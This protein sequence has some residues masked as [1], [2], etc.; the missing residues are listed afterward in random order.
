MTK[1]TTAFGNQQVSTQLEY[2]SKES[3]NTDLTT[4]FKPVSPINDKSAGKTP[5][6]KKPE[7]ALNETAN[8]MTNDDDEHD[9]ESIDAI[10]IE[11]G[12]IV[13]ETEF[14]QMS[15]KAVLISDVVKR[16]LQ[17]RNKTRLSSTESRN[18]SRSDH[19]SILDNLSEYGLVDQNNMAN[20]DARKRKR[21]LLSSDH[22]GQF[23]EDTK[24][25][26]A[27][28]SSSSSSSV[29]SSPQSCVFELCSKSLIFAPKNS[30]AFKN[31]KC[32]TDVK[33]YSKS[34]LPNIFA[35][36]SKSASKQ[37]K[38]GQTTDANELDTNSPKIMRNSRI[39]DE[40]LTSNESHLTKTHG[41]RRLFDHNSHDYVEK[42]FESPAVETDGPSNTKKPNYEFIPFFLSE[43]SNTKA[44]DKIVCYNTNHIENE[45]L[46]EILYINSNDINSV[47]SNDSGTKISSN[48][49]SIPLAQRPPQLN[50]S[51]D[52]SKD[53][54]SKSQFYYGSNDSNSVS[55]RFCCSNSIPADPI[56]NICSKFEEQN[57]FA[58]QS[59][60]QYPSK[61]FARLSC[62]KRS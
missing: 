42:A 18:S 3:L 43:R 52:K 49:T 29:Q 1:N 60:V 11:S 39:V 26:E 12:K 50:F 36:I 33:K 46:D 17:S 32:N 61:C 15:S 44:K 45:L 41:R 4:K 53:N 56:Q 27:I 48:E 58:G 6:Q 22:A 5:L 47:N 37:T 57:Q 62:R 16:S 40:I 7:F 30:K 54:H 10:W 13:E 34:H 21:R 14:T 51:D 24:A 19:S 9:D 31:K 25:D 59:T 28:R 23:Y 35:P 20:I 2:T 8:N 55:H 38:P